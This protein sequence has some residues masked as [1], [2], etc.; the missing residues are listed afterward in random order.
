V[1]KIQLLFLPSL[2]L[3]LSRDLVSHSKLP[4]SAAVLGL[5]FISTLPF[6]LRAFRKDPTVALLAPFLLAARSIA[7]LLGI[8]GGTIHSRRRAPSAEGR[9]E[10]Q[11]MNL[12]RD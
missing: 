9:S 3:A 7:Q 8:A 11:S 1:M 10:I 6:V 2:L 12:K 4:L 5:F